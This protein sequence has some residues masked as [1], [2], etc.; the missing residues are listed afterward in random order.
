MYI[1]FW[2]VEAVGKSSEG[3]NCLNRRAMPPNYK[4]KPYFVKKAGVGGYVKN[5]PI[6]N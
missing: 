2:A 3:K 6:F 4:I 1:L 5:A